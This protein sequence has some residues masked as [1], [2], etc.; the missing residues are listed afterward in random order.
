MT[1]N[2]LQKIMRYYDNI[3]IMALIQL[4]TFGIGSASDVVLLRT[5]DNIKEDRAKAFFDELSKGNVLIDES[6]LQSEDFLHSYF[7]TTKMA[8]NSRRREKIEMFARL[9]K[10]SITGEGLQDIDE[11]EDFLGIL[12]DLSYR[13]IRALAIMDG[14]SSLP[15]TAEQ[16]DLTWTDTFWDKFVNGLGVELKIPPEEVSDFMN[17]ISRTG[18]YEMFTGSYWG[19]TGG[20]G[21]LTPIYK[22]LKN[23]IMEKANDN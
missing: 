16:N 17:R 14:F 19:Y 22:K 12:D 2:T 8:L 20:K 7:A 4:V 23:F 9:L 15:Q 13:E 3:V 5:L 6:I 18:C 10:Y 1:E 11:Y 21:K